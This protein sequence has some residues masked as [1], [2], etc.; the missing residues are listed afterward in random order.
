MARRARVILISAWGSVAKISPQPDTLCPRGPGRVRATIRHCFLSDP[1]ADAHAVRTGST[2]ICS[3]D[4]RPSC[5]RCSAKC[6]PPRI[7]GGS[8]GRP[9]AVAA[10]PA[11][12]DLPGRRSE[13][14][15][16]GTTAKQRA[17]GGPKRCSSATPPQRPGSGDRRPAGTV[18]IGPASTGSVPRP[19]DRPARHRWSRSSMR[20]R[21]RAMLRPKQPDGG[22]CG[23]GSEASGFGRLRSSGKVS[24]QE[25]RIASPIS[26][27]F[28]SN[29]P[30]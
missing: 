12:S 20:K 15:S 3:L 27:A 5:R 17:S 29:L 9:R 2:E 8:R 28:T 21:S 22:E 24:D 11:P 1:I 16:E 30:T 7:D 18:P 6:R 13:S 14:A 23:T 26:A 19:P 10:H 4:S 25:Q